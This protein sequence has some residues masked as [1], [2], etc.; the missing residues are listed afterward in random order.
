MIV[1]VL[2][3][4]Q[5]AEL[6][7]DGDPDSLLV[8]DLCFACSQRFPSVPVD[9]Q[10]L[11]CKGN[12][13]H[14]DH[15]LIA[16]DL[17]DG[18]KV[19]L[20]ASSPHTQVLFANGTFL[21]SVSLVGSFKFAWARSVSESFLKSNRTKTFFRTVRIFVGRLGEKCTCTAE[22]NLTT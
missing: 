2:F 4:G 15:S 14:R 17:R 19:M 5:T 8:A 12:I 21:D 13:L 1:Q 22:L 3:S 10:K 9:H 11:L 7:L 18:S 6:H 20:L 16:C